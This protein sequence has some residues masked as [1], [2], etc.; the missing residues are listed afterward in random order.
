MESFF[1]LFNSIG[2]K[3]VPINRII[4][5]KIMKHQN[6]AIDIVINWG[7]GYFEKVLQLYKTVF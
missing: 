1:T 3:Y 5:E 7:R 4:G 6:H 2:L